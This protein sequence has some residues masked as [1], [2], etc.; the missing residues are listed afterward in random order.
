MWAILLW[1]A[2][3]ASAAEP[4]WNGPGVNLLGGPSRDGKILS[5]VDPATRNLAIRDLATGQSRTLTQQNGGEYAYFSS[6]SRDASRVAYAWFNAEGFYELRIVGTDSGNS[7]TIF[8]N[9]EAGFVQP[10]GWTPDDRYVLTLLFRKDNISQIALIPAEGGAPKVLRSLMWVYPKRMDLSPDGKYIVY[11]SFAKDNAGDRTLFVLSIDGKG[12]SKLIDTPGDYLFPLWT[13]DGKRVVYI[14]DHDGTTD[15]WALDVIEGK[16]QGRPQLLRRDLGRTLPMGIT[17][18]NRFIYGVRAGET[19]VFVTSLS[20]PQADAKRAS[21]RYPGRNVNP[22]WSRDGQQLAYLSRRGS[23]NFGQEARAIVIRSLASGEERELLP[24][25]AHMEQIRWSPDGASLLVSGSDGKGRAGLYIVDAKSAAVTPVVRD[26]DAPFQG[27]EGVWSGDG[28]S[29]VYV[30]R[31]SDVRSRLLSSGEESV[32]HKGAGIHHLVASP[33][34]K[35]FAAASGGGS[36]LLLGDEA[37][38]IPFSGATELDWSCNLIAARG[39]ELWRIPL[40][41]SA[42]AP[43]ETP[44]NRKPGFSVHPDGNRIALTVSNARSEVR[45]LQLTS[46]P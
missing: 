34:G 20:A 29:V 18:G 42:P 45:A 5:Y 14:A 46:E 28:K 16:A 27:Y 10:C 30:H 12:E 37:R 26:A 23:E 9:E 15:L 21:V 2:V 43:L 19:D 8:R 35:T 38:S 25:L 32:L 33:D 36:I 31:D 3:V 40:D 17:T 39:A 7:R 22:T 13:P 6:I 4:L 24:R 44:G 1:F 41:G 11:D